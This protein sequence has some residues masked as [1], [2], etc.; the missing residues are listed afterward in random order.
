MKR[1]STNMLIR[2]GVF[3]A[4]CLAL[5]LLSPNGN[6]VG[7]PHWTDNVSWINKYI[8]SMVNVIFFKSALTF[9]VALLLLGFGQAF[10]IINAVPHKAKVFFSVVSIIMICAAIYFSCGFVMLRPLPPMTHNLMLKI[11]RTWNPLY[12]WWAIYAV[13]AQLD[14]TRKRTKKQQ[15]TE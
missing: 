5:V 14:I 12:I 13:F 4:V 1:D 15:T 6:D 2:R 7:Y 9:S 3:F 11:G 10:G 8:L